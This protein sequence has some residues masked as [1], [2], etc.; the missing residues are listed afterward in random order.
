MLG[1]RRREF[2]TLV[3]GAASA[4]LRS[5]LSQQSTRI[6]RLGYLTLGRP[7]GTP[8][9]QARQTALRARLE[10]L[11]WTDGVNIRFDLGWGSRSRASAS[12]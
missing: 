4:W 11:G 10:G 9:E 2:I 7:E 3:G 5:A 6:P 8:E 1:I 12:Q